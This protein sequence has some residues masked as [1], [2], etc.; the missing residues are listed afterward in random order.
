MDGNATSHETYMLVKSKTLET[1][2]NLKSALIPLI[3]TETTDRGHDQ[4]YF[5]WV[6]FV[7]TYV[8]VSP[9]RHG[10]RRNEPKDLL[11]GW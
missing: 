3:F 11:L 4:Q 1:V 5:E 9:E 10:A 2:V 7:V 6:F 8:N